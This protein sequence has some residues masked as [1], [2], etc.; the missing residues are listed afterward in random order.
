[1][2]RARLFRNPN[3]RKSR[4]IKRARNIRK[5]TRRKKKKRRKKG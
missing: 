1:M 4:I 2:I 3:R 5:K